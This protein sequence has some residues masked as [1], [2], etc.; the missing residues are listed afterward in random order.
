MRKKFIVYLIVFAF[1]NV[2][3][4]A[5]LGMAAKNKAIDLGPEANDAT[6]EMLGSDEIAIRKLASQV[7]SALVTG[8][9]L[10]GDP[11]TIGEEFEL[12]ASDFVYGV[13]D[14]NFTE[15][16]EDTQGIILIETDAE[17]SFKTLS[18]IFQKKIISFF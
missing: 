13:Y 3:S 17:G 9:S 14:D 18:V 5:I 15:I 4:L 6:P 8:A 10:I 2:A 1:I 12:T 11:D 16:M 7:G